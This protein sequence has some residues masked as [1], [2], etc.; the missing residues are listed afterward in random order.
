[1]SAGS[2]AISDMAR[3]VATAVD[4]TRVMQR[5][6]S[7]AAIGAVP[8]GGVDRPAFSDTERAATELFAR[9][10]RE[11]GLTVA[12]D[13]FGN[14]FGSTDGNAPDTAVS[15]AGSHLDTVP[16]GGW[17]DGVIGCVGALEVLAAMRAVGLAP[18]VPM[19]VVVWRS[20]E[21][22]RF[23]QGRVG[24]LVY[25]GKLAVADLTPR[26]P[27]F[28]VAAT[29]ADEPDRPRRAQGRN[30]TTLLELHIE[31]GRR[32]EQAGIDIGVV[33]AI[34]GATRLRLTLT[35]AA[36]HS[37]AT[38]MRLR[39]DALCAA[40]EVVLATEKAGIAEERPESV[41]TAVILTAA[42]GAMNVIPGQAE[43]YLDIRS[44]DIASVERMVQAISS[45]A[46][47]VGKRRGIAVEI[48]TLTRAAPVDLDAT[49][50]AQI[51]ERAR[52]LGYSMM[53]MASG[54]GHDV[55]SVAD[56]T[57]TGMIFV[58][59]R[60]GISHAP[61][62]YTA[63]DAILRGIRALAATWIDSTM[64]GMPARSA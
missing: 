36:D 2:F 51:E 39:H 64:R 56:T 12:Y 59:S 38:P 42:P 10:M 25:A 29:L 37:G 46:D 30:L 58:P 33:T 27:T 61:E 22:Y 28:D 23:V 1:M 26:D 35:G 7:L 41:A 60:G 20:E 63:P 13:A 49:L 34:S 44:T 47:A 50:V 24:S 3:N 14:L 4:A 40:A 5:I 62:E 6:E 53:R 54:A 17:Y 31:Q 45:A 52:A 19:E 43:L 48:A 21:P 8:N 9:W 18:P 32:L 16:N 55:Q 57:R 15:A 11:A